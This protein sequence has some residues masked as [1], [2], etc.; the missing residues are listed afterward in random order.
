ML[1]HAHSMN[2]FSAGGE[3]RKVNVRVAMVVLKCVKAPYLAKVKKNLYCHQNLGLSIMYRA[4]SI[5]RYTA[6]MDPT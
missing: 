1:P 2:I 5:V 4:M 3:D 6:K